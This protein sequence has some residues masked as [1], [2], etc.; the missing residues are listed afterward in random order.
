[1]SPLALLIAYA[2]P[3]L[4]AGWYFSRHAGTQDFLIA[5][6]AN[7]G[8]IM[9]AG[10]IIGWVDAGWFAFYG[11][12]G[13][14]LGWD[15][16]SVVLGNLL[17][18]AVLGTYAGRIKIISSQHDMHGI[19]DWFRHYFG[20]DTARII[21][22]A[23]TISF[24]AWLTATFVAAG[25]IMG[26]LFGLPYQ[27]VIAGC[28]L[29]TLP[30]LM[31]GGYGTLT[32]FDMLQM[33]VAAVALALVY[34]LG[35]KDKSVLTLPRLNTFLG[36]GVFPFI[37]MALTFFSATVC[38]GDVWQ[39]VFAARSPQAARTG[40]MVAGAMS[41]PAFLAAAL[42]GMAAKGAGY[43]GPDY[44]AF[45]YGF[46][47]FFTPFA[48]GLLLLTMLAASLST[49]NVAV[50]GGAMSFAK[51]F[52]KTLPDDETLKTRL[53]YVMAG[54]VVLACAIALVNRD[55]MTIALTVLSACT[56]FVPLLL[57]SLSGYTMRRSY[58]AKLAA[59]LAL[60]SYL[61]LII[62]GN[63]TPALSSLP[64]FVN[65]AVLAICEIAVIFRARTV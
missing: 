57:L 4:L 53:Q 56:C 65:L 9:G 15:S 35:F 16:L 44:D 45:A 63:M 54:M 29:I 25:L 12:L 18:F 38:A 6:R 30:L 40:F 50:F 23:I 42:I 55:I 1:M 5:N 14:T 11:G 47:T 33:L 21:A 17:A 13:Y 3:M 62:S 60:L 46:T 26:Q 61:G 39:R 43:N 64:L 36:G 58:S 28:G 8:L 2:V 48:Q 52:S 20:N 34:A 27:A 49:I 59:L 41:I 7:P 32:K 10:I 31:K 51:D 22:V 24:L 37:T 19:G